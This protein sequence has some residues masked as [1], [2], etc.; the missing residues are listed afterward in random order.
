LSKFQFSF[1]TSAYLSLSLLDL[2]ERFGAK[3]IVL[4]RHPAQV[5]NSFWA[6]GW[7]TEPYVQADAHQALGYQ[8]Q[9]KDHHFFARIAPRGAEFTHWNQMTRMGK[10]A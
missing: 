4:I 5:V 1:E 3:F 8:S 6:K 10:L 9:L 7:Y 2:Y